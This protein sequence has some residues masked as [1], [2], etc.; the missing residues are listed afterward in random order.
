MKTWFN[1]IVIGLLF[2]NWLLLPFHTH[3]KRLE[4]LHTSHGTCQLCVLAHQKVLQPGCTASLSV[5][6]FQQFIH[7]LQ[8]V[9]FAQQLSSY[10]ESRAPPQA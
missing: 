4:G 6:I 10:Q 8:E 9:S 5:E 7:N 2:F 3:N 1:Q